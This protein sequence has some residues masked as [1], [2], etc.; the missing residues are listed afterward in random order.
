MSCRMLLRHI[1]G[2]G[3][4]S[5]AEAG[6]KRCLS[7]VDFELNKNKKYMTH[8][9]CNPDIVWVDT[10]LANTLSN[11]VLITVYGSAVEQLIASFESNLDGLFDL[12]SFSLPGAYCMSKS[13]LA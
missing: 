10:R 1:R 5:I 3:S 7:T 4:C 6:Q 9:G 8:L 2:C 12:A 13:K 11:L